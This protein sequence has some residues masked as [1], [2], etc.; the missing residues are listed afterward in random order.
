LVLGPRFGKY[1]RDGRI[2]TIPGH[3]L[4]LAVIGT[5][6]LWLGWFGFNPGST[7]AADPGLIAHICITT[8]MAAATALLIATITSSVLLGKPDLG[9]SINGCL[10]G[11]VAITA[12]CAYVTVPASIVI[13]AV[14]GFLVVVAVIAFDKMKIDDP[15]GALAVHLANGVFGTL[16]VGLFAEP[17]LAGGAAGLFY[18]GGLDL[19][20]KQFVGVVAVGGFV[21]FISLITWIILKATMGLRVSIQEEIEGLDIGEHGNTCYPDFVTR[22]TMPMGEVVAPAVAVRK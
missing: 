7:M 3:N 17:T 8:N 13:G 10:A 15:V 20:W 21:F 2:N 1:T 16:A 5:F 22:K 12:G 4:S 19:L 14:A 6:I 9:M 11:L 18:G